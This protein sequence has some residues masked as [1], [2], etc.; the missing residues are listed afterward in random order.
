MTLGDSI[1]GRP[2]KNQMRFSSA[3]HRFLNTRLIVVKLMVELAVMVWVSI[4]SIVVVGMQFH[5]QTCLNNTDC[6]RVISKI[7]IVWFPM[8][9]KSRLKLY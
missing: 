5:V 2:F 1:L 3:L 7:E 8:K 6:R 4:F 9:F